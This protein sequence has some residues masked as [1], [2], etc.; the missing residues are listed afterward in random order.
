[1][2]FTEKKCVTA[3]K[4]CDMNTERAMEWIF[5]HMDDPDE[6]EPIN[7]ESAAVD[8]NDQYK[9][10]KPGQYQLQSFITH[11]GGSVHAGHYV[12]HINKQ[13]VDG[14]GDNKWVYFNDAKVAE[15]AEPPVGKGYM[16][17]FNKK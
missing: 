3:L 12:C 14:Q 5:S 9:C 10:T 7:D 1:M 11:L 4:N 15:T 16:Y 8:Q 6:D 13:L 17:F 2:G